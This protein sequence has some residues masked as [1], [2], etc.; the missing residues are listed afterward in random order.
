MLPTPTLLRLWDHTLCGGGVS[1]LDAAALTLLARLEKRLRRA[2]DVG[3]VYEIIGTCG[4]ALWQSND[5]MNQLDETLL[6]ADPQ[7]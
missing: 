6:S 1:T 2:E 5:F 3:A 4:P 7:A